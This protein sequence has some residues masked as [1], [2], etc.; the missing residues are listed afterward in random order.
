MPTI[1]SEYSAT[2]S[3]TT[4]ALGAPVAQTRV[5]QSR[6]YLH[7]PKVVLRARVNMPGTLTYP[8]A[9]I[10]FDG[11][12]EG[13]YTD[14][15]DGM[16]FTLGSAE[17]R[18]DYGRARITNP[19]SA[20]TIPIS[21]VSRGIYDGELNVVDDAYLTVYDDWRIES[22][23][24]YIAPPPASTMYK[25]GNIEVGDNTLYPP[26]VSNCGPGFAGDID[27]VTGLITIGFAGGT[28]WAVADGATIVSFDWYLPD[29]TFVFGTTRTDPLIY[30]TFEK[31]FRWVHLLVTDS[32]GIVHAS[33]CPVLADDPDDS[34]CVPHQI[35]THRSTPQG[36]Q[37]SFRVLT[38]VPRSTYPDGCLV[39][40]FDDTHQTLSFLDRSHMK[41]IGWHQ[42]DQQ[43]VKAQRTGLLRDTVL[44]C[45]DAAG[46]L[47]SLPGFS[48]VLHIPENT[49]LTWA[50]I[51]NATMDKFVHYLLHWH[52]TALN[53]ADFFNPGTGAAYPFVRFETTGASLLQQ[54]QRKVNQYV[55]PRNL[56]C[57]AQGQLFVAIDPML[58]N[59]ADRTTVV[60]GTFTE[61]YWSELSVS[62][63]RAPRVHWLRSSA[64]LTATDWTIVD[65]KKTLLTAY[66]LAPG[67]VP[68]Q[69]VA[70]VTQGEQLAQSQADL[71]DVTGHRYARLNARYALFQ[72]NSADGTDQGLDPAKM[73]WVPLNVSAATAAQRGLDFT[74]ARGLLREINRSFHYGREGAVQET[75]FVWEKETVGIPAITWTP[76]GAT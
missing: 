7:I 37:F 25:E 17:G 23:I 50:D 13:I 48:Q 1:F 70:E 20:T 35:V 45:V 14:A 15:L 21:G 5:P 10:V 31:G 57:T 47:D 52:S 30:A 58:Q 51:P 22:R 53:M 66:S 74:S 18:D 55:P 64:L 38:D 34:L 12:S 24:P 16:W 75:T 32:N 2:V 19:P 60:Q 49:P 71:N 9:E 44:E 59:L 54:V 72:L 65:G 43:S 28:S 61:D 62:Y 3:A 40:Y 26:P 27:P 29:G 39:L 4:Y 69:G 68:S 73:E 11:V 41:F 63:Q 56:L 33:R 67:E 8:V 6:V 76:A 42:S 36:Q 46:R